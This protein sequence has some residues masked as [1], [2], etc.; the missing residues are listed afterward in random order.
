MDTTTDDEITRRTLEV[1]RWV[2]AAGEQ[3][4]TAYTPIPP[5]PFTRVERLA[6]RFYARSMPTHEARRTVRC[7]ETSW[8]RLWKDVA[9]LF[10]CLRGDILYRERG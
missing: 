5:R 6:A 7:I 8:T 3:L 1:G 4:A 9:T 10:R 2:I